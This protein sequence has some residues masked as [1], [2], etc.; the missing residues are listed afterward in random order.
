[1]T[2]TS[3]PRAIRR[4]V[5]TVGARLAQNFLILEEILSELDGIGETPVGEFEGSC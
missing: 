4:L 1:M 2:E 3:H 5:V